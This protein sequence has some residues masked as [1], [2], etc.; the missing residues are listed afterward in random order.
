MVQGYR[1]RTFVTNNAIVSL[2]GKKSIEPQIIREKIDY[3]KYDKVR[4]FVSAHRDKAKL[5]VLFVELEYIEVE[6]HIENKI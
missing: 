6:L 1:K 4:T 2:I 5:F 3:E